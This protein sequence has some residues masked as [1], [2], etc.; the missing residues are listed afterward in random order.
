MPKL[1]G[2]ACEA[3]CGS[4]LQIEP[5]DSIM[6]YGWFTTYTPKGLPT[7]YTCSSVCNRV[8]AERL[9]QQDATNRLPT[10]ARP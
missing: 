10:G 7:V 4:T 2:Y 6:N 3:G 1:E 5:A 9:E 8:A